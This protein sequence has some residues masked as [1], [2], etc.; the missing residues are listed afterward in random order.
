MVAKAEKIRIVFLL[1]LALCVLFPV[2]VAVA[3]IV[4]ITKLFKE[5]GSYGLENY[6]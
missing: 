3:C 5:E 6:K 1:L 4:G 2:I